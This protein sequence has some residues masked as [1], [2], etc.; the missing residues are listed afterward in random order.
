MEALPPEVTPVRV[1][2]V[3]VGAFD[4]QGD[5]QPHDVLDPAHF[6]SP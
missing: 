5:R 3:Q 6:F 1:T 2:A 4:P